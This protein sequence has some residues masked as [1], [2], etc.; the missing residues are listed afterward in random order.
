MRVQLLEGALDALVGGQHLVDVLRRDTVGDEGN[1]QRGLRTLTQGALARILLG[2]E[3]VGPAL[4][5]VLQLVLVVAENEI[6]H[7]GADA[8]GIDA[9]RQIGGLAT[10]LRVVD[11]LEQAFLAANRQFVALD[12]DD[13]PGGRATLHLGAQ[14]ADAAVPGLVVHRNAARLLE[15]LE[16]NLLLGILIRAAPRHDGQVTRLR[17]CGQRNAGGER[18]GES[19]CYLEV[20]H[21]LRSFF[22]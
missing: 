22:L 3:E 17:G 14:H 12:L 21:R 2:V 5:R 4:R 6:V 18:R 16:I 8:A 13:I 1:L 20:Q 7:D 19:Q 15:R 11:L 10:D 9:R